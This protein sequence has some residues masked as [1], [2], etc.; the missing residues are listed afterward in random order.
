MLKLSK[1]AALATILTTQA[2]TDNAQ[3]VEMERLKREYA[4][5]AEPCQ[6]TDFDDPKAQRKEE[7]RGF[8]DDRRQFQN[9]QKHK[10]KGRTR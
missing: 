8:R 2:T 5:E 4:A 6:A 10:M 7:F 9:V 3:A 1:A